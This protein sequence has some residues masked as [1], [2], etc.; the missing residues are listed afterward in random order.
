MSLTQDELW[1]LLLP[2][3]P[4]KKN[5][6]VKLPIELPVNIASHLQPPV[7][8]ASGSGSA[9]AAGLQASRHAPGV[10]KGNITQ[11]TRTPV[12]TVQS[13]ARKGGVD[14]RRRDS[15]SSRTQ[16]QS[17]SSHHREKRPVSDA[18]P[19]TRNVRRAVDPT[20]PWSFSHHDEGRIME[21]SETQFSDS[22]CE[23]VQEVKLFPVRPFC[24]VLSIYT[25]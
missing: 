19:P 18:D 9:P 15:S 16:H 21:L 12:T 5:Q 13:L 17:T 3:E 1:D 11:D 8:V 24:L 6:V 25:H 4:P 2:D 23:H 14:N 20:D 7:Q 10:G 22:L